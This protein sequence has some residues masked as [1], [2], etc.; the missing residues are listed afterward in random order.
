MLMAQPQPKRQ[1]PSPSNPGDRLGLLYYVFLM[2]SGVLFF[3]GFLPL[4]M[5]SF[6]DPNLLGLLKAIHGVVGAAFFLLLGIMLQHQLARR[7]ADQKRLEAGKTAVRR[8]AALQAKLEYTKEELVDESKSVDQAQSASLRGTIRTLTTYISDAYASLKEVGEL[9]GLSQADQEKLRNE[10]T[11]TFFR[12]ETVRVPCPSCHKLLSVPQPP[13]RGETRV[14]TCDRC[15]QEATLN[16]T[17]EESLKVSAISRRKQL[18]EKDKRSPFSLSSITNPASTRMVK[19]VGKKEAVTATD[20]GSVQVECATEG[21]TWKFTFK[22]QSKDGQMKR[23]CPV[24]KTENTIDV[25]SREVV[26]TKPVPVTRYKS[27]SVVNSKW[28]C[29]TC[30]SENEFRPVYIRGDGNVQ[31]CTVCGEFGVFVDRPDSAS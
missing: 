30:Q 15:E 1:S 14:T 26:G 11:Q 31:S 22:P 16:R 25:A 3:P 2:V 27:G 12:G 29:G 6:E 8:I 4:Y 18:D 5:L 23:S 24:C 13:S 17:D 7:M 9:S 10:V 19:A 28:A 20:S 21:C